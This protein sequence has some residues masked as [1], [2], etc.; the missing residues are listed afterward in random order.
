[1]LLQ[2]E[3]VVV[4]PQP[5]IDRP[6][7]NS[8][9]E[10]IFEKLASKLGRLYLQT[11]VVLPALEDN[12]AVTIRSHAQY[13]ESR[14]CYFETTV[15]TPLACTS[16][17]AEMLLWGDITTTDT[18]KAFRFLVRCLLRGLKPIQLGQLIMFML[19]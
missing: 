12:F 9:G 1:M 16:K 15:S 13:E 11:D 10:F 6:L 5:T 17:D 7:F 8:L 4:Q 14:E 19:A 18:A 2:G 3:S